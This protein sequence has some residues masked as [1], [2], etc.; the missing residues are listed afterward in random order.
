MGIMIAARIFKRRKMVF[1][2]LFVL[3]LTSSSMAAVEKEAM[4]PGRALAKQ[5]VKQQALWI[6][7]DHSK[8]D[9]LK[10]DFKSGPD[11]TEACIS[12]HTEA[13]LQFHQT[14]H[15]TWMDPNTKDTVKLGKGGLS[16]N[17]F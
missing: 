8:F 15:W 17:N 2:I 3:L 10:S 14:I 12:C 7:A 13:S 4:A 11:V 6:T 9:L 5:T 1:G 16:V